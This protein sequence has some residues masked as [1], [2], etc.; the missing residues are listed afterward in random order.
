[1]TVLMMD[2]DKFKAV[3]DT[4]GHAV[5]AGDELLQQVAKRIKAR[6]RKVDLVARLNGDE[7]RGCFA[8]F[9]EEMTRKI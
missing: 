9:S 3:N 6:L 1:M 8:C 5:A 2:L 7:G 4:L